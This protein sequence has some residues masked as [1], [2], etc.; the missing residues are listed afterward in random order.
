MTGDIHHSLAKK[1]YEK[2]EVIIT[3]FERHTNSFHSYVNSL[4]PAQANRGRK[5]REIVETNSALRKWGEFIELLGQKNALKLLEKRLQENVKLAKW[6]RDN[7]VLI[8]K[9][10]N[11]KKYPLKERHHSSNESVSAHVQRSFFRKQTDKPEISKQQSLFEIAFDLVMAIYDISFPLNSANHAIKEEFIKISSD[12][13]ITEKTD[14]I[15]YIIEQLDLFKSILEINSLAFDL[16]MER[17]KEYYD[18]QI[19]L[20]VKQARLNARVG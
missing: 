1:V 18:N 12:L 8:D 16:Q 7:L 10:E 5:Q 11:K 13:A 15:K 17:L 14:D 6:L 4:T 2:R 9:L 3:A 19:A 20:S